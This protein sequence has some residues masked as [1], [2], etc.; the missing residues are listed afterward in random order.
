MKITE[1]RT[2]VV[3]WEGETVPLPPHFSPPTP[4]TWFAFRQPSM[5]NFAFHGWVL[6]EILT[7]MGS[8]GFGQ[9]SAVASG[10]EDTT[11]IP[12]SSHC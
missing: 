8:V 4:W 12:I 2:R 11:S 3:Q 9:R 7:D 6:V 10:D 5:G 1:V